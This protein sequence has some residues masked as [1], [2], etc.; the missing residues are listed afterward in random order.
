MHF[1]RDSCES[2][3]YRSEGA[4]LICAKVICLSPF[5]VQD[6]S[7]RASF[8]INGDFNISL[9]DCAFFLLSPIKDKFVCQR[10]TIIP[11]QLLEV[12]R[13]L[14]EESQAIQRKE[15]VKNVFKYFRVLEVKESVKAMKEKVTKLG[16]V[17][18]KAF[19]VDYLNFKPTNNQT[20]ISPLGLLHH[21][22]F[23][24]SSFLLGT[25]SSEGKQ[26]RCVADRGIDLI[27][28]KLKAGLTPEYAGSFEC[29]GMEYTFRDFTIRV[30]VASMANSTTKGTLVEIE[31]RPTSY[32]TACLGLLVQFTN[33][34]LND[35]EKR[36]PKFVKQRRTLYTA[37]DTLQ[38]YKDVF[39]DMRRRTAVIAG[40]TTST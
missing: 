19:H 3:R 34:L 30:G 22:N 4:S 2:L 17:P 10:V 36:Y 21:S 40:N 8:E 12:A 15:N 33:E 28:P 38:Q 9:G 20:G 18:N 6:W 25:T 24:L 32:I 14:A 26:V 37:L 31:F 29:N 13:F 27:L 39:T 7:G 16:A 23:P 1:F 11:E 35:G 5:T